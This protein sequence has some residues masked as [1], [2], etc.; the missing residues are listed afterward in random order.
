MPRQL[1]K[2]PGAD[3]ARSLGFLATWWI[4]TFVVQGPGDVEG[5][6]IVHGD[7]FTGFI[8]DCY[9]LDEDGRRVHDTAFFSR[10]K[11]CNKSGVAAELVLFEALGPC[12][13]AGWAKGGETFEFLGHVYTYAKGEPMGKPV[14]YPFV[15]I[16]ATEDGQTG[17]TYDMVFNNLEDGPLNALKAYGM[18]VNRAKVDL[19]FGGEIVPSTSG[20]ASKDGGKETFVVFDETHLY[21]TTQLHQMYNTVSRNLNKRKKQAEPWALETTTMYLPGEESVA[22]A[23]YHYAQAI[24]EATRELKDG[25]TRKVRVKRA[26]L[27]F[28]HRWGDVIDFT[29][30]EALGV[31]IEE[32]YGEALDWNSKQGI[33]DD[34]YDPRR[35]PEESRRYFLNALTEA[36]NAWVSPQILA[37]V[38]RK[39]IELED[40]AKGEK[41]ALGFDGA[42][43]ND[44][45]ALIGCRISDGAIFYLRIEEKPDGPEADG[46]TVDF[47]AFDAKVHWAFEYFNVVAFHADPPFWQDYIDSWEREWGEQL[48]VKASPGSAI[49]WWTKRDIPMSLALERFHQAMALDEV[50]VDP[51]PKLVRHLLNARRWE[52]RGGTVIGKDTKNSAKKIDGA[53]AATLAYE[54]RALYLAKAP[55]EKPTF[56]PR[57]VR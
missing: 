3:R 34:L 1:I 21:N 50:S 26:K 19:P 41:I 37:Q 22:E 52:R 44:S 5:E 12:R 4:E 35:T 53:M 38:T 32:A 8:L 7:E 48:A 28:D 23:T 43:S 55:V 57:R 46:W 42:I 10:P 54:A 39:G 11:G 9:I 20:A 25:E 56:V 14:K 36:H 16:M 17:N 51:H 6:P 15:R 33:I 31:A 40:I 49:K 18:R 27:L 2:A 29:D 47:L 24:M 45:T 30:E 13:F